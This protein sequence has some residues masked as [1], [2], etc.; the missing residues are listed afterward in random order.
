MKGE[1]DSVDCDDGAGQRENDQKSDFP[2]IPAWQNHTPGLGAHT[3]L[4]AHA[5]SPETILQLFDV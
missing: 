4:S 3:P 2:L 5:F 1:A